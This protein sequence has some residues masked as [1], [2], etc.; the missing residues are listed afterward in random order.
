MAPIEKARLMFRE[1]GLNFEQQLAWYLGWG[2]VIKTDSVFLMAKPINSV[3]GDN[4]WDVKD[5]DAWYVHCLVGRL[6]PAELSKSVG[7]SLP[8]LCFRRWKAK[9][10]PLKCY[11]WAAFVRH[12]EPT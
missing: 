3:R 4:E 7:Y 2:T 1:H 6:K 8:K 12:A 10:N 9:G 11:D 5:A